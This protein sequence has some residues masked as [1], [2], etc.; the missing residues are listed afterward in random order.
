MKYI[1][2]LIFIVSLFCG[3]DI[4]YNRERPQKFVKGD[5][6]IIKNLDIEGVISG[7]FGFETDQEY[8]I[9]YKDRKGIMNTVILTES[10]LEKMKNRLD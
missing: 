4:H 10:L 6:V 1:V 7:K 8:Y 2:Y 3:C 9:I 5:G